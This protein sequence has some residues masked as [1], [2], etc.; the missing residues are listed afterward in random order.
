MPQ[1]PILF[2]EIFDAWG[3]DFMGPFPPSHGYTYILLA[4]DYLS[5]WVEAIP[6]RKDDAST[7]SKFLKSTIFSRF[8]VPKVLI[9]DQ[10]TNFCNKLLNNLLAKYGV[11]HRVSTPYHPQTNGLAEV[12]N[13]EIKCILERIVKP[14]NRDWSLRLDDAL[15]AYRTTHK[16]PISMSPYQIIYGKACHLPVELEHRSYW[17]V[18]SYNTDLEEAGMNRFLQIQELEEMQLEAYN[19]SG[20]YKKKTKLVHDA[21]ILRKKFKEGDKVLR[22]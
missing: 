21:N 14:S 17:A 4:V 6:T 20:I 8:G 19:S 12:S 2:C 1:Q 9:S 15:W 5:R 10:G 13:R 18:K 7:V 11:S 16:T 22:Y 3:V